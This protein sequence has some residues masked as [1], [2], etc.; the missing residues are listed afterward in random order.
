MF[1]IDEPVFLVEIWIEDLVRHLPERPD[2][3]APSKFPEV[4]QDL[5]LVVDADTAAG[6]VLELVRSHR[7]GSVRIHAALFDEYRGPG[8][9]DGKKSLALHLRFQ[10]A[11]RTLTDSDVARIQQGLLTR[12]GKEFGATLRGS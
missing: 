3:E 2:Y 5:A 6:K 10:A 4:R 7:S 1:D 12:L 9:P 8:I 11:D